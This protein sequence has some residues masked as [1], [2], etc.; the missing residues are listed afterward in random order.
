M[1]F[2]LVTRQGVDAAYEIP[3]NVSRLGAAVEG[4]N[5]PKRPL[6]CAY[7]APRRSPHFWSIFFLASSSCALTHFSFAIYSF[8]RVDK[9]GDFD[10]FHMVSTDRPQLSP[11]IHR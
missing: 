5:P 8:P 4:S 10:G 2:P 11:R 3:D 1:D 7:K 9:R 6:S